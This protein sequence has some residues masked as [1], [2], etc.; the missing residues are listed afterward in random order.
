MRIR[1]GNIED[2]NLIYAL[3]KECFPNEAWPRYVFED[4]L[5][6]S[7]SIY[8]IAEEEV[9]EVEEVEGTEED[10]EAQ[11]TEKLAVEKVGEKQGKTKRCE[12][13][14]GPIGY[15]SCGMLPDQAYGHITS[16]AVA[17]DHRRTG[18]GS[19]L[20]ESLLDLTAELG[21]LTWRAETRKSNQA[22][23]NLFQ[24][25]GFMKLAVLE[26]FYESPPEDAVLLIKTRS[27]IKRV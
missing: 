25:K 21:V 4:D 20:L 3:E 10:D 23:L 24:G 16:L 5:K 17:T 22:S 8:L 11:T 15:I 19:K 12:K 2:L 6:R 7:E 9:E 26:S 14:G 27:I 18:V 1:R 13:K